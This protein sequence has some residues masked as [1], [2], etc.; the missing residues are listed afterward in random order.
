MENR[1]AVI[2][3]VVKDPMAVESVNNLFHEFRDYIIGRMGLPY[4]QR[5]V[6]VITVVLD[7]SQETINTL[8]GKLGMIKNV[9]SKVLVT[10]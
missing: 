9:T 10:K 6:S 4:R 2:A 5:S 8:S 1:I 7:A 3:A